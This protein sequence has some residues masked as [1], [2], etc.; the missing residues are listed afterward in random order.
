MADSCMVWQIA[1]GADAVDR[2]FRGD[3]WSDLAEA[4]LSEDLANLVVGQSEAVGASSGAALLCFAQI[5]HADRGRLLAFSALNSDRRMRVYVGADQ[6]ESVGI[7]LQPHAGIAF[8]TVRLCVR[9]ASGAARHPVTPELVVVTA[10]ELEGPVLVCLPKASSADR[11]TTDRLPGCRRLKLSALSRLSP[12]I[13]RCGIEA[14][15]LQHVLLRAGRS[16]IVGVKDFDLEL[17]R[18]VSVRHDLRM[19]LTTDTQSAAG[20]PRSGSEPMRGQEGIS[21]MSA[22]LYCPPSV[23]AVRAT[24]HSVRTKQSPS[25]RPGRRGPCHRRAIPFTVSCDELDRPMVNDQPCTSDGQV[26]DQRIRE[27]VT[28]KQDRQ[29]CGVQGHDLA[30]TLDHDR[31]GPVIHRGS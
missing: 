4:S 25:A 23:L 30:R 8:A 20:R 18:V 16:S 21:G 10:T 22:S 31:R 12:P 14:V 7:E 11:Y 29:R 3:E 24:M 15:L 26:G 17:V 13:H 6:V 19:S 1:P 28:A 2:H 9:A 5:V 27:G